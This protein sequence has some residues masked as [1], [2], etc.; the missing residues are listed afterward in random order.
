M[1]DVKSPTYLW[2]GNSE[3]TDIYGAG[4]KVHVARHIHNINIRNMYGPPSGVGNSFPIWK[5]R[6]GGGVGLRSKKTVQ[7]DILFSNADSPLLQ[8]HFTDGDNES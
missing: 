6:G 4:I 1:E 7:P 8:S 3:I 2:G 5:E